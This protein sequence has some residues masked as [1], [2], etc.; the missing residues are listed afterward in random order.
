[1]VLGDY[2]SNEHAK[3]TNCTFLQQVRNVL[4]GENLDTVGDLSTGEGATDWALEP[5]VSEGVAP[6]LLLHPPPALRTR[7]AHGVGTR[8]ACEGV[9][10][11]ESRRMSRTR[12]YQRVAM[13]AWRQRAHNNSNLID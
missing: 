7:S 8:V 9:S 4:D 3:V 11:Y 12:T 2:Q 13:S 10:Y 1:M 5:L 6:L